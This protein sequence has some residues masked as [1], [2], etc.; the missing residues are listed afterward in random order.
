MYLASTSAV[1]RTFF[2]LK[3]WLAYS[4]CFQVMLKFSE[5]FWRD[6]VKGSTMFGRLSTD[7]RGLFDVFYD[8]T[9]VKPRILQVYI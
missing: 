9:K 5:P 4:G 1:S 8:I 3:C 7:T 6:V 2:L